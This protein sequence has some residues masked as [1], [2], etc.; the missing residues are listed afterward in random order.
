MSGSHVFTFKFS[1][2]NS[3]LSYSLFLYICPHRETKINDLAGREI[4]SAFLQTFKKVTLLTFSA[5]ASS[6]TAAH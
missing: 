1:L 5:S 6:N 3:S 2:S 4:K